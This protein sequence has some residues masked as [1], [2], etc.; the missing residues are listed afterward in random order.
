MACLSSHGKPNKNMHSWSILFY[1]F[2]QP[3]KNLQVLVDIS[4]FS[5]PYA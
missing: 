4:E 3:I 1:D 2:K 5:D